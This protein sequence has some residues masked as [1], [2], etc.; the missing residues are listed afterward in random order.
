M[1]LLQRVAWRVR[2]WACFWVCSLGLASLRSC[3]GDAGDAG[4]AGDVAG[5]C[6]PHG[7]LQ[8]P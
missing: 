3:P 7:V 8:Q 1:G 6:L 2:F 5:S 4:D